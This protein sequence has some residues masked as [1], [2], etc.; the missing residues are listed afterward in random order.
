VSTDAWLPPQL[1][2]RRFLACAKRCAT[3]CGAAGGAERKGI[4]R[5]IFLAVLTACLC[6]A[7]VANAQD[8]SDTQPDDGSA[9]ADAPAPPPPPSP[10]LQ[11]S[12]YAPV[13]CDPGAAGFRYV[14]VRGTGFD[15]WATQH[16]VGNVVDGNGAP[17]MQWNSVWVSPQGSL[18][19]EVNLCADPFRS[20]PALPA[21]N[22]TISI[23]AQ[24]GQ[25]IAATSI[26][27]SP[28]PGAVAVADQSGDQTGD[29][30][31]QPEA[32]ATPLPTATPN[33]LL[34]PTAVPFVL[35]NIQPA[36]TPTPLPPVTLP[37]GTS[38][39]PVQIQPTP[40]AQTNGP[41]SRQH[42]FPLG[43]P[44]TLADGWQLLVTGVTPDAW[45][46]IQNAVPG[47]RASSLTPVAVGDTAPAA[48][49]RDYEVN[50][51]ATFLGQG[52]GV[53]SGIRLALISG[54]GTTYDQLKNSCGT[55]PNMIPPNLMTPG[56]SVRGIVCFQVR[57]TDIGNL[58]LF[59]NQATPADELY[60][61]L[62]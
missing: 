34:T 57:A 4:V 17:Q 23:G 36:A 51:N 55:V 10:A 12:D 8:S 31:D 16:L 45:S 28:P 54:T 39:S 13:V 24:S 46:G 26:A 62:Q 37:S 42:P 60:F 50:V 9:P 35:P 43:A 40:T 56:G 7:S 47:Y 1:N 44:G 21:G 5:L 27:L 41:G 15:A 61:A 38:S 25:P 30:S 29:D 58:V 14:E 32:T 18:T 20:R 19:L 49:L 2:A 48:D 3:Q 6:L 11:P 52:T 33:T 53:F 59:D 22:Y